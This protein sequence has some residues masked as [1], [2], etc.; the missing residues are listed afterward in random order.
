MTLTSR[1]NKLHHL[2]IAFLM[3]MALSV[4]SPSS[5]VAEVKGSFLY[6]LSSFTGAIPYSTPRLAID[7]ARNEINVLFQ[8]DV[9]VFNEHGMEI[10]RFGNDLHIGQNVDLTIDGDGNV[11]VL[12]FFRESE[13]EKWT[14]TIIR[15][16]YRGEPIGKIAVKEPPATFGDFSPL[17]MVY[18]D[19]HFYLA[20]TFRMK[21]I[22][23]DSEG[24]FK[25]G[26]DLIPLL[27]LEEKDRVDV[28]MGGFS[29]GKDGSIL[30]TVPARFS[31]HILSPDGKLASFGKPGGAPGKFNIV[32]GIVSDSK[33]NYLVIDKLKCTVI[34]F[35]KN[36]KYLTQFGYRGWKSG[37]LIAPEDI[38]IDRG[39]RVYV[40]QNGR[41]GVSVYRLIYN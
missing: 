1:Y 19:G 9:S 28:E 17:R 38:A 31:A 30:F 32:T 39:G 25:K 34:V 37:E 16:N 14:T 18:Q 35:D 6:N 13:G 11:M 5:A 21:I 8:N 24:N 15:C 36:F 40:T 2:S 22:V 7:Q 33:G 29:V 23:A 26:Y 20:D 4:V 10:Y 12:N 27:G 3:L 41:K